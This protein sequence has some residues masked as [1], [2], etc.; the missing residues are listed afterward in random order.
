[1]EGLNPDNSRA[2]AEARHLASMY[3][4]LGYPNARATPE[5]CID[6]LDEGGFYTYTVSVYVG[7]RDLDIV[8]PLYQRVLKKLGLGQ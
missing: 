8:S 1:M 4:R 6:E 3:R 7:D 5:Y 2:V